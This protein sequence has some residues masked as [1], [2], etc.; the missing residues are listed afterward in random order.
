[1]I[2]AD[3]DVFDCEYLWAIQLSDLE[4]VRFI[5]VDQEGEEVAWTENLQDILPFVMADE[6][7]IGGDSDIDD[8]YDDDQDDD[9]FD[10][11]NIDTPRTQI[12]RAPVRPPVTTAPLVYRLMLEQ[13]KE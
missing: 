8:D 11:D 9:L 12:G 7:D 4:G 1:M 6:A 2:I 13:T 3:G 10:P 5:K